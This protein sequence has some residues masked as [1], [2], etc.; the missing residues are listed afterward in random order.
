MIIFNDSG[1]LSHYSGYLFLS[2]T[3]IL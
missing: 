2:L 3:L 1:D